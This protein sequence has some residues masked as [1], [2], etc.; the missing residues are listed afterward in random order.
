VTDNHA[1]LY[2]RP[3]ETNENNNIDFIVQY[4]QTLGLSADKINM[5][6]PTYGQ[7]WTL[8]SS[9]TGIGAPA[10]GGGAP[11]PLTNTSGTLGYYEICYYIR[12][13]GWTVV[14]DPD[15]LTGPYAYSARAENKTWV[16][17]DDVNMATV[18]S[19]YVKE[20]GLGGAMIWDMSTDDFKNRCGDGSNPLSTAIANAIKD[21]STTSTSTSTSTTTT[22]TTST[23]TSTTTTYINATVY[24]SIELVNYKF[25]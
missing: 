1:P 23:S 15:N 25:I 24:A 8:A 2:Q 3:L 10:L 20:K 16:G 14:Q 13:E 18:K 7:S 17:Y 5:G 12:T 9:E 4:W 21:P 6:I 19:R 22:T 11:G